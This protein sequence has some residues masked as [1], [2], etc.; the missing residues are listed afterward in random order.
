MPQPRTG[1]GRKA[2]L[3]P[4]QDGGIDPVTGQHPAD[5]PAANDGDFQGVA[6]P[7]LAC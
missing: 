5:D 4:A 3:N 1:F 7:S 2:W 6:L